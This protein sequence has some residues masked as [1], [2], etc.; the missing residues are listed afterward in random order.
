MAAARRPVRFLYRGELRE[1]A[2][3]DPSMTVLD[4]LRLVQRRTGTKEGCNEGDCGA[5]TVVLARPAGGK[6]NYRAVNACIQLLGMLDGCQ[7]IT[8]EDLR[9]ADGALHPVQQA[10]ADFH[11]SQ[12]GFCTPGFVMSMFALAKADKPGP[13]DDALSG[14]LCRCTGYAPIVR[15][16]E[17]ALKQKKKDQFD[18]AAKQTLK[19]LNALRDNQS[20]VI[21]DGER[22]FHAPVSISEFARLLANNPDASIIAGATDAGLWITKQFRQPRMMVHS[23]RVEGLAEISVSR[24]KISI[25]AAARY[26]DA[27][28]VL[29]KHYPDM[30]AVLRR[31]GSLQ[32]RNAGTIGGNIGNASPVGDMAPML[33]AAGATLHLRRGGKRRNLPLEDYFIAY[34]KQDRQPGEFIERVALPLP[35]RGLLFKAFKVSKR[36]D[37][38]ISAVLGAFSLKFARGRV[39]SARIAFGGMAAVPRRALN[40]EKALIG[41]AWNEDSIAAAQAALEK[42]FQPISDMRASAAYRLRV[43]KNLLTRLLIEAR[44]PKIETRLELPREAAHG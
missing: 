16:A 4:W 37:D 19:K 34:G 3:A 43:A 31:L 44:S 13:I 24:G 12:C 23:A 27:A 18:A 2:D 21:S 30:A 20:A 36:F 6:L 11:G 9:G 40:T 25:G 22:S 7:L 33:I 39:A 29:K 42:D 35:A 41:A 26:E 10:L 17:H 1:I 8:V 14:N 5:C 28:P 15:A 32:I 38:D